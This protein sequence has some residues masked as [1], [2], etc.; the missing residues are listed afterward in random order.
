MGWWGSNDKKDSYENVLCNLCIYIMSHN[1]SFGQVR[2]MILG[3][4]LRM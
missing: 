4:I 1:I 2:Y 3:P